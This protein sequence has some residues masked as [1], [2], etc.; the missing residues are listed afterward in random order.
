MGITVPSGMVV[1]AGPVVK[2]TL[3]PKPIATVHRRNR[4]IRTP[5]FNVVFA[6]ESLIRIMVI[7]LDI[8]PSGTENRFLFAFADWGLSW[9]G[10]KGR[11]LPA[12]IGSRQ[13]QI[14]V[15]PPT[16]SSA[17]RRGKRYSS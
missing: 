4:L 10:L 13:L 11:H 1:V 15:N 2:L 8:I 9:S 16:S 7:P 12:I 3:W 6:L 17:C 5:A 14:R